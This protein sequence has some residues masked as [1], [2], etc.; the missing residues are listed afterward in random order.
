MDNA[1]IIQL[2]KEAVDLK[3][4]AAKHV[5]EASKLKNEAANLKL[6]MVLNLDMYDDDE[7]NDDE[8]HKSLVAPAPFR[9]N[10]SPG[11]NN[12]LNNI[13]NYMNK[14]DPY[15]ETE[16]DTDDGKEF[17]SNDIM[18][19]KFK[20]TKNVHLKKKVMEF[21]K[22][23][24]SINCMVKRINTT[25]K[26]DCLKITTGELCDFSPMVKFFSPDYVGIDDIKLEIKKMFSIFKTFEHYTSTKNKLLISKKL[27]KV[28]KRLHHISTIVN[29]IDSLQF[30]TQSFTDT[31][32]IT[33]T[34]F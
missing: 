11:V 5:I 22:L 27:L 17:I 26:I 34:L 13:K 33:T 24:D 21:T 7:D 12:G 14:N 15:I 31:S 23:I 1:K 9:D 2:K 19:S 8:V 10:V 25:F 32:C 29:E 4:E 16:D 20:N 28:R 6:E 18:T 3:N 30:F